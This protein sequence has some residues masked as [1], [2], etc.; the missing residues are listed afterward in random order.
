MQVV[1]IS[2]HKSFT[3]LLV[4]LMGSGSGFFV[5][6]AA[7]FR[8]FVPTVIVWSLVF[9]II[10]GFAFRHHHLLRICFCYLAGGLAFSLFMAHP[11]D[12]IFSYCLISL[13]CSVIVAIVVR[14]GVLASFRPR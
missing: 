13:G 3:C 2:K 9:G 11:T 5:I 10:L 14:Y 8:H 12:V 1:T 4:A 7:F 6:G